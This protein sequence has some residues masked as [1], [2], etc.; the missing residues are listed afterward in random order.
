MRLLT[1]ISFT[2]LIIISMII[3]C[4]PKSAD[5]TG[6]KLYAEYCL[7]C[8]GLDGA[9]DGQLAYLLYPKPRDLTS[10]L[11]K[12]R[13]TMDGQLPSDEDLF[14]TI[15]SGMQGTSM[16]AF[17]FLGDDKIRKIVDYIK[18]FDPG[19]KNEPREQ[20]DVPDPMP[21]SPRLV[22]IGE[23]TYTELG[24]HRCHGD[25][26]AGDGPSAGDLKD[27]WGYPIY[28]RDF[29]RGN[30][31]G[32]YE[33]VDLYLRFVS[34]MSGTPMPSYQSSLGFIADT[35]EELQEMLWGLIHYVKELESEE[36]R[37]LRV[38]PPKDGL[39]VAGYV[40]VQETMLMDPFAPHWKDVE[41]Y[42]IPV[43]RIWQ[44]VFD[45]AGIVRVQAAHTDS[46][47]ALFL[48]WQDE[49]KDVSNVRVHDFQDAAAIQFS[50]SPEPGFHG[51]GSR[52]N[53]VDMWFWRAAWQVPDN[54]RKQRDIEYAYGRRS[55][56]ADVEDF[57]YEIGEEKFLIGRNAGNPMS[58]GGLFA[59]FENMYAVGP[60]TVT[61]R[62]LE[63]QSVRGRGAW[64]GEM[65][66]VVFVR[67]LKTGDDTA[68]QLR[69]DDTFWI[70]FAVWDGA[71]GDRDG[72]KKVSTWYRLVFE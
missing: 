46:H 49:H 5:Q 60:E 22:T 34:G 30:Y 33:P 47:V 59:E 53:P 39:I 8:H 10:G 36:A 26:G 62:A 72:L 13:S 7:P 43:S 3:G 61:S 23:K 54:D 65:W 21:F 48:E 50:L 56:D 70:S 55:S 2:L 27:A 58:Y 11:F 66:R 14:R 51:M 24:C 42:H 38:D 18:E 67:E 68:M 64:D 37:A 16:P 63:R 15:R 17:K 57:P 32:G 40:N 19:F 71:A 20:I 69:T 4:S 45:D 12:L 35:E 9:G 6:E 25:T 52:E 44:T 29:T 1:I 31:I 28:V 41:Q